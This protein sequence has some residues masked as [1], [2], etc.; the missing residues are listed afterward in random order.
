MQ[1]FTQNV[2][3]DK[4]KVSSYKLLNSRLNFNEIRN[5]LKEMF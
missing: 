2:N 1:E 4:N 5:P 3:S